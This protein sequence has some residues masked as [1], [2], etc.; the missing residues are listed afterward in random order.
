MKK[1]LELIEDLVAEVRKIRI[2]LEKLSGAED[3][4]ARAISIGYSK[5]WELAEQ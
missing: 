5:K 3:E 4:Q 2:L 1:L